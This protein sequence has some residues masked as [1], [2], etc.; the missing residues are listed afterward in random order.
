LETQ[1]RR[2]FVIQ[3]DSPSFSIDKVFE[4]VV[5][6]VVIGQM[7]FEPLID[8][9]GRQGRFSKDGKVHLW[10]FLLDEKL[11]VFIGSLFLMK[12]IGRKGQNRESPIGIFFLQF[13]ELCVRQLCLAS[14]RGD[15]DNETHT[16]TV[17]LQIDVFAVAIIDRKMINGIGRQHG[18][19][20]K[21]G[22][23]LEHSSCS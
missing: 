23:L 21:K 13:C 12:V 11:N 8:W 1:R 2:L 9:I 18:R 19:I 6:D 3:L 15:V 4:E 20:S 10:K 16:A 17:L 5:F 22:S 14:L 7:P